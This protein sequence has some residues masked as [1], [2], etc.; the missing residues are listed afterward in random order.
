MP[1]NLSF[2]TEVKGFYEPI[3]KQID[4]APTVREFR[5]WLARDF[6]SSAGL[7]ALDAGCGYHLLNSRALKA[8][9]FETRSIDI[10]PPAGAERGSVL[11]IAAPDGHFDLV[12]CSGVLHHTPDP[13]M[14]LGE[15]ARVLK[16][17]G[18]C[19][20]SL[21]C[22]KG[23]AWE[24]MVRIWRLAG[25]VLPFKAMHAVFKNVP[26]VNNFVLDHMY[27]PTLWL[28]TRNEVLEM[29]RRVGLEPVEDFRSVIDRGPGTG[30]GLLRVFVLGK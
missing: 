10:N 6:V 28:Y 25:R 4:D 27:V 9:G 29:A 23:T 1:S 18:R 20:V 21:Y 26:A 16:P 19:Y 8:A 13:E 12:V 24:A 2:S 17:S 15:I 7:R 5:E 14:G 11:D 3:H 22:F 30:D